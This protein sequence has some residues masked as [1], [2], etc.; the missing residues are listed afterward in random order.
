MQFLFTSPFR[1]FPFTANPKVVVV[2]EMINSKEKIKLRWSMFNL[3]NKN[4]NTEQSLPITSSST[5]ERCFND[6]LR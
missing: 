2:I 6:D 3:K 4:K 5:A 1:L